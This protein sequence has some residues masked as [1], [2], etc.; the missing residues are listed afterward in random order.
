MIKEWLQDWLGVDHEVVYRFESPITITPEV[1][2]D[3]YMVSLVTDNVLGAPVLKRLRED[4][5]HIYEGTKLSK[6][7]MLM[8]GLHLSPIS[9]P[10]FEKQVIDVVAKDIAMHGS[11][12]KSIKQITGA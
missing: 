11:V 6:I 10:N 1:I 7:P 8:G 5:E 3:G 2:P 9:F 12:Y 4:W